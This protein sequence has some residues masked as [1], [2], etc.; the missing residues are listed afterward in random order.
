MFDPYHAWLGIPPAEQ[1]PDHYRVL[2]LVR[3]ESDPDVISSAADR[4][5]AH[6]RQTGRHHEREQ[7]A[8]LNR[9]SAARVCLLD[10]SGREQYDRMLRE[11]LRIEQDGRA[12]LV[13][14]RPPMPGPTRLDSRKPPVVQSGLP[15]RS[16]PV[17]AKLATAHV[18]CPHCQYTVE[19]DGSY[20]GKTVQCP[21]CAGKFT[22]PGPAVISQGTVSPPRLQVIERTA[23]KWKLMQ[24]AGGAGCVI[25]GLLFAAT[26]RAPDALPAM[27]LAGA[28]AVVS[29]GFYAFGRFGAWWNHG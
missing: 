16:L 27:V 8:M 1:P 6:V 21:A 18:A 17:Q 22:V 19:D 5:M 4:Q 20:A 26:V 9:L 29:F 25:F 12:A 7:A 13:S 11:S 14:P 15:T 23:K 28:G 2:G 3:F 10:I 24:A